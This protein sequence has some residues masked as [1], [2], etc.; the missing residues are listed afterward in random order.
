MTNISISYSSLMD[1]AKRHLSVLGKRIYSN[2]GVNM[3]SDI[4]VSTAEDQ[5]LRLYMSTAADNVRSALSPI[6][7]PSADT[8]TNFIF[9]VSNDR[10]PQDYQGRLTTMI[11][12][13]MVLFTVGEYLA[14]AHPDIAAKYT[15]DHTGAMRS[16]VFYAYQ[17]VSPQPSEKSYSDV[18]GTV[19]PDGE[20]TWNL[21]KTYTASHDTSEDGIG[22][23]PHMDG[24]MAFVLQTYLSGTYRLRYSGNTDTFC[25]TLGYPDGGGGY[26][27]SLDAVVTSLD[28]I[29]EK[30]ISSDDQYVVFVWP[31]EQK[32]GINTLQVYKKEE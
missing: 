27:Y 7:S 25:Y 2:G 18:T 14:M 10:A 3:F 1:D 15:T 30:L 29:S 22:R 16:L 23:L 8:S 26:N 32:P 13:Y 24:Y 12:S 17:K 28:I 6:L 20:G 31:F 19:T 5:I 21:V 9:T 11:S 4:T